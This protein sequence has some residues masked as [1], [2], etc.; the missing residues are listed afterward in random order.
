MYQFLFTP[1]LYGPL[2]ALA[3][4]NLDAHSSLTTFISHHL[5]TFISNRSFS[6]SSSRLNLG[7]SLVLLSSG[8][9][10]NIFLT[11]LPWIIL[12]TCPIHSSLFFF[13]SATVSKSLYIS[14]NFWLLL[15]LY[16]PCSITSP[17]ILLNIFLS[18]VFSLF[19]SISVIVHVSL[20]HITTGFT[21][22]IYILHL[23]ALCLNI[24]NRI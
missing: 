18:H 11:A 6:T 10:W 21:N 17:Y 1:W 7:L 9:P 3:F 14:D 8:L 19:I 20:P 16:I 15:I 13:M 4:L 23:T 22:I 2:R 5:I 12:A 24:C